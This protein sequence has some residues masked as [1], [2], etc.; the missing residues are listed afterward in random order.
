MSLALNLASTLNVDS[1]KLEWPFPN[2]GS[3]TFSA[4][5]ALSVSQSDMQGHES[6]ISK[7]NWSDMA[8]QSSSAKLSPSVL[9][10]LQLHLVRG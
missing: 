3:I 7:R 2:P 1:G 5:L 4:S 6:H 10:P 9:Q 8:P